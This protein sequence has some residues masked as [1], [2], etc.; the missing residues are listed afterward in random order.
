MSTHNSRVTFKELEALFAPAN[1]SN[2][3][4]DVYFPLRMYLIVGT[5]LAWVVRLVFFSEEAASQL[6]K[7]STVPVFFV[8]YLY[9]RGWFLALLVSI[10]V[11]SYAK[12][13]FPA[14]IN[15]G[16]T[17]GGAINLIFDSFS[18][19]HYLWDSH[20]TS[21][22]LILVMRIACLIVLY[23]NFLNAGA[24][25][26]GRNRWDPLLPFRRRET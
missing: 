5:C 18:L 15:L 24:I 19:Y 7:A 23:I 14:L 11:Y 8:S 9:F 4:Q 6:G 10:G 1:S 3:Q 25:P 26:T 17:V 12:N 2:F 21:F 20:P 16:F 22:T 13:W